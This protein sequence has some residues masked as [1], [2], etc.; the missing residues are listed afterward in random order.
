MQLEW[1]P[2]ALEDREA[3]MEYIAKDNPTAAIAL[4]DEF[5]AAVER[6]CQHPKLYKRGRIASTHEIVIRHRY[7]LIYRLTYSHLQVLRVL[8]TARRW[9]PVQH[10]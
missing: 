7:L 2:M 3:I 9:P 5:E 4:D 1:K 8:H 6:A 10:R